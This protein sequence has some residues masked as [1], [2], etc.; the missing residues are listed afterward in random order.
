MEK[1]KSNR[2]AA[3]CERAVKWGLYLLVF[4]LPLFFLPFNTNILELNKQLLLVVF[5]L[6]L[7]IAWLGK[8]IAQGKVEFKKSL[9]NI[10]LALFLISVLISAILSKN[11]YQS[12]VGFGG[13]INEAF[14]SILSLVIIFLAL[15][16]NLRKREEI[17][18]VM[19]ALV[20]SG[21]VVGVFSFLQLVGKFTLPWSFTQIVSFNPVGSINAL[22]VFL[23]SLLV[24]SVVLFAEADTGRWRQILFGVAAGFFLL[25]VL[26][27]N[28]RNVWWGLLLV[29][30]IIVALGIINREQ[31]SQYR[32]ILPMTILAFSV[33]MLLVRLNI[34][35]IF[36]VPAE[37]SPSWS[38][39]VSIDKQV[40]KQNLFFGTGPGSYAA[41]YGLYRDRVLNQTDFWNIR[42]NQGLSKI[43][44]QPATLGLTGFLIWLIL[45]VGFAVYGFVR[46]VKNRG[47]NWAMALALFSGWLLLAFLQFSYTTN[48]TLEFIFWIML[49][50][51]FLALK[52][53]VPR[54]QE[55]KEVALSKIS[56]V[57]M[58]LVR[59]SP[60]ASIL[61]FIFVI[62]LVLTISVLYLGGNY[63][64]ADILYQRGL[65]TVISNKIEEGL[66]TIS[67]AV[68]RNPYND[69]YLRSSAQAALLLI[70]QEFNKPV[71]PERDARI[72]NLTASAINIA[73]RSTD[74][75][76]LNVD[77]W[78]QRAEIYRAVMSYIN[79]AD[80]WAFDSYQEASKLEPNNPFYY[81]ELGW[82]YSLAVDL[83]APLAGQDKERQAKINEYLTKAEEALS[84][85]VEVKPDYAPALF[86]LALVQDRQGKIDE[87]I[88]KM[89]QT[90]AVFP[91]DIGVAFQ[92]ALLYYKQDK[93]DLARA[94]FERAVLLDENYSNARYF[95]GLIYDRQK[96]EEKAIE[97]FER[98]ARLN[99]D[100]QDVKNILTN[101][102]A[103]KSAISPLAPSP[104]EL[105]IREKQP[106]E[107]PP[108]PEL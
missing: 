49:G 94:E 96:E 80:Q 68:L 20:L 61:S 62:V 1:E 74:L 47:K 12:L 3:F 65:N 91:R 22:E 30:M 101:L 64:Y 76:P 95:L 108:Q 69:L 4:L 9:L 85:A 105:P 8:M 86:Q 106:Q 16:N 87:A 93:L 43:S 77:N 66:T 90:R 18:N 17:L 31:I 24:L 7:L 5:T 78:V 83:L 35:T 89:E 79:G 59:S 102:R 10:G 26:S 6:L 71:N 57:S 70:N 55:E 52:S 37:V 11:L 72:Q 39:T 53:L 36:S 27:I 63:Y 88:V 98:I 23:A 13:T 41:D 48:L 15:V 2:L 97:Q 34:F 46:L 32:L 104:T 14:F 92:L 50:L 107:Q 56:A 58:T 38:A 29:G 25:M 40:L 19:F 73:K 60:L 44:S 82:S 100:N 51:T 33:L 99:P 103:G 84:Q 54:G 45:T 67:Q 28:F 81:L 21:V 42:F 75:A